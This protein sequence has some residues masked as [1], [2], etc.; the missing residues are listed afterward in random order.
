MSWSSFAGLFTRVL[1]GQ[2]F[3]SSDGNGTNRSFLPIQCHSMLAK[4]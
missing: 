4:T 3:A 1:F 2:I